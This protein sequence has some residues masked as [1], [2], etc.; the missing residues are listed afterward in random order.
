MVCACTVNMHTKSE[1]DLQDWIFSL[2]CEDPR[3][4]AQA[5]RL[6]AKCLHLC[7][8]FTGPVCFYIRAHHVAQAGLELI[9][10]LGPPTG[11]MGI[12]RIH[13]HTQMEQRF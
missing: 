13:H 4:G 12:I 3:D 7:S 10:P 2:H 11:Y 9:I 6:D 5:V 1:D 8:H